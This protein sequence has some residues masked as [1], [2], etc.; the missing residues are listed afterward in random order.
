MTPPSR[1][2]LLFAA[3]D[4]GGANAILPVAVLLAGRGAGVAIL[5]HG[6]L[7]RNAP[8]G[9]RRLP[10][11]GGGDLEAWLDDAGV[12]GLCFGT[13]L[14]DRL[15][16]SLAR[17][18]RRRGLPVTGVLDNWM[19]Y[20]ARLEM[21]GGPLLVPD[22]YAVMD[23]KARD[24]ALAEGV[25]EHCLRVTGHPGLAGLAGEIAAAGPGWRR[26]VRARLG[27][28]RGGRDLIAFIGEPVARDQGAGPETPGWRGYTER[29][30]LPLL[31]EVLRPHART[32]DLA[33][34]PHPRDDVAALEDLWQQCRGELGGG[35]V[36]DVAGRQ[37]VLAADRVAGMAS[38]LL[39][40][41][42]LQGKPVLSLQPGLVRADLE[43]SVR[44]PGIGL[45]TQSGQV[46]AAV[47][48]WLAA[49]PGEPR[50]DGTRHGEAPARLADLIQHLAERPHGEA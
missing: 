30:V 38:I 1:P 9:L 40:E 4:P 10:P 27:L 11:P 31:C 44:R 35:I 28:G 46:P 45:A 33:I 6:F 21:D 8:A 14:A 17:A 23:D 13:S 5:D 19:N 39:Y 12:D 7:G 26:D 50:P 22:L 49:G 16:L 36:R 48:E 32:L 20:R 47:A 42:W 29:D 24:E 18:A 25:P 2:V 43:R 3:A 37:V 15:P 41:A 34:V